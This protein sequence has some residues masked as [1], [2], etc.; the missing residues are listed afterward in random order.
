[1]AKV[2]NLETLIGYHLSDK[3]LG[4]LGLDREGF[5]GV[6]HEVEHRLG[7]Q[8]ATVNQLVGTVLEVIAP[9]HPI[10]KPIRTELVRVNLESLLHSYVI[11][12]AAFIPAGTALEPVPLHAAGLKTAPAWRSGDRG[13]RPLAPQDVA[14]LPEHAIEGLI[15][16][17]Y[18]A[19]DQS[20]VTHVRDLAINGSDYSDRAVLL[21]LEGGK[22][23]LLLTE[24]Y[25]AVGSGGVN[26]QTAIRDNRLFNENVSP[27]T[28]LT[29]Y[30]GA[31]VEPVQ[32]NLSDLLVNVNTTT[33]DKFALKA[34]GRTRYE[35]RCLKVTRG[36]NERKKQY[37]DA[38]RLNEDADVSYLFI[39]LE[40]PSAPLR[41][42]MT[43]LQKPGG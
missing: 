7:G 25:K 28:P 21:R 37:G 11:G 30:I 36:L 10:V 31:D 39:G 15:G 1:M 34:A 22:W 18:A 20:R 43:A 23:A 12:E 14:K 8:R 17:Q 38:R 41:N 35:Q 27:N 33:T 16:Q 19:L 13:V 40:Y 6:M 24:E 26:P 4:Q 3:A 42:L 5:R 29:F 32:I 2:K 9:N